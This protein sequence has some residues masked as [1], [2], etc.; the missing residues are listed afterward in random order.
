V[1]RLAAVRGAG[2]RKLGVAQ[3]QIVC[4]AARDERQRLQQLDGGAREDR[5]LDIADRGCTRRRRRARRRGGGFDRAANTSTRIGFTGFALDRRRVGLRARRR[6]EPGNGAP[7][8][9]VAPVAR[10][11]LLRAAIERS[12]VHQVGSHFLPLVVHRRVAFE[13]VALGGVSCV[14]VTP[15]P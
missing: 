8:P 13:C 3:A 1:N 14:T 12:A 6:V 7:G 15:R 9:T 5:P 11:W 4:R 2:E 10:R